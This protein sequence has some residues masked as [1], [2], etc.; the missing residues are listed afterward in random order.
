VEEILGRV[1]KA[2][3]QVLDDPAPGIELAAFAESGIQFKSFF[4]V[5][6]V[7]VRGKVA[8]DVRYQ[9]VEELAKAGIE[10]AHPQRDV[11]L[12]AR[13]AVPVRLVPTDRDADPEKG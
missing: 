9:L 11:H 12:D 7:T 10:L 5:R 13:R 1:L 2:H 8:S 4:W 6:D 3:P